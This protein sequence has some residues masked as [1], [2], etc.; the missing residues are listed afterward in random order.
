MLVLSA[1]QLKQHSWSRAPGG[2]V[3]NLSLVFHFSRRRT[4]GGGNVKIPRL[5][6]DFQGAVGNVK[7]LYLVFHVFHG[8]GISTASRI[9][10][11]NADGGTGSGTLQRRSNRAL[12]AFI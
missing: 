3:E 6:R 11:R 12:A 5:L 7:N 4:P 2:K 9:R 1:P 10:Y 8:P